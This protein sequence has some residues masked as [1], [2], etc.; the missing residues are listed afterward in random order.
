MK[1][2]RR[3]IGAIARR[4]FSSTLFYIYIYDIMLNHS[5]S[6]VTLTGKSLGL[7]PR[8]WEFDSPAADHVNC[9]VLLT[10]HEKHSRVNRLDCECHLSAVLIF[11]KPTIAE[12]SNAS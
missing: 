3:H 10:L 9:L 7:D 5:L 2:V 6:A 12:D 8:K 4:F 11:L 1:D